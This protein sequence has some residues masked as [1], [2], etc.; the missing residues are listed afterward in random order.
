MELCVKS[1]KEDN[2]EFKHHLYDDQECR[3][4]IKE[5]YD[6]TILQAYDALIPGAYRADLWRY[7]ILYKWGGMYLDI[8]YKCAN[9]F[10]LIALT[11]KEY[12]VNDWNPKTRGENICLD[13]GIYNAFMICKPNNPIMKKCID[14]VVQNVHNNYYGPN[15]LAPTG[16][17][18]MRDFFTP[19]ERETFELN[20]YARDG[21]VCIRYKLYKIMEMYPQYREEQK[22]RSQFKHYGYL[23]KKRAIYA[24]AN[25]HYTQ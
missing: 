16:P 12:F 5:H 17:F 3:D 25:E 8:K 21:E 4:F 20:H 1:L 22:K 11:E 18:M 13:G 19:D 6:A 15:S 2:P 23:W 24:V 9:G 14:R 10:K 7:C